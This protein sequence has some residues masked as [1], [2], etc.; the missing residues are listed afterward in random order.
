MKVGVVPSSEINELN[1]FRMDAS[2]Y[3]NKK[4]KCSLCDQEFYK[5]DPQIKERK[6]AHV[7]KHDPT[8]PH[9]SYNQTWGEV[10][11]EDVN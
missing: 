11:W 9:G 2:Y 5:Y 1:G 4:I 3:L 7:R 10:H 8:K 6:K